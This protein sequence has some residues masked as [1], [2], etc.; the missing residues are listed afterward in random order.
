MCPPLLT[1][2]ISWDFVPHFTGMMDPSMIVDQLH[3]YW[4]FLFFLP[5]HLLN[6]PVVFHLSYRLQTAWA[7]H[8]PQPK[9]PSATSAV[10]SELS[11]P[12]EQNSKGKWFL[13]RPHLFR[14]PHLQ[15]SPPPFSTESHNT[16]AEHSHFLNAAVLEK[17]SACSSCRH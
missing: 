10:H 3:S 5:V 12:E 16:H 15:T 17:H 4:S 7:N 9:I 14:S 13:A 6:S 8:V 11:L 1:Q 2:L